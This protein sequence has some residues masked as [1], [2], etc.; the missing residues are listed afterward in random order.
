VSRLA[1]RALQIYAAHIL[2]VVVCIAVIA[3]VSREFHEPRDLNQLNVAVFISKPLWEFV[4]ALALRYRPVN[5]DVLPLYIL[6]LGTFAPALWLII[7]K[8]TLTLVGSMIVYLAGRH[9]GW[10]LPASPSGA[11]YFNPFGWCNSCS[12]WAPGSPLAVPEPSNRSFEHGRSSGLRLPCLCPRGD[13]GDSLTR[14]W[15][16]PSGLDVGTV[17]SQRQDQSRALPNCAS[18]RARHC[19]RAIL[20]GGFTGSAMAFVDAADQMRSKL[21]SGVL[22]RHR[23]FV[24]RPRCNRAKPQFGLGSDFRWRHRCPADDDGRILLDLVQ[25]T[26]PHASFTGST[27]RNRVTGSSA[28]T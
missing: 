8:P 20:A 21:T 14:S 11:W 24:L 28:R 15:P 22:R 4:Q 12:A 13:H 23:P 17:R 27:R 1:K 25:T 2:V 10:N 6:L 18:H 7:R 9:F 26:G 5:L 3:V 19:G 16:F